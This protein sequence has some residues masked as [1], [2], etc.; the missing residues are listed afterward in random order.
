MKKVIFGVLLAIAM[1]IFFGLKG[2]SMIIETLSYVGFLN[3]LSNNE[4]FIDLWMFISFLPL[5]LYFINRGGNKK[6]GRD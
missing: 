3:W 1:G 6:K 5:C 4:W 2:S